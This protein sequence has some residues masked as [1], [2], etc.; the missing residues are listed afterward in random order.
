MKIKKFRIWNYK[1]IVDSLD[2]YPSERITIFAGMNEAGKTS[3]LEALEDFDSQKKIRAGAISIENKGVKP[4]ISVTFTVSSFDLQ[5]ML[6][7]IHFDNQ[8]SYSTTD[9]CVQKDFPDKYS[10]EPKLLKALGLDKK[11]D[12]SDHLV[13][14]HYRAGPSVCD[15]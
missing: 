7:A 1:S 14:L 11:I 5:E 15:Q 2:C 6:E 12:H 9:V 13:K 8:T 3:I 4:S 10:L